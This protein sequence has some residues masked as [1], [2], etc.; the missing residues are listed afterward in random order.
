MRCHCSRSWGTL[1]ETCHV[2]RCV[3]VRLS[4]PHFPD[5][6][7]W[8]YRVSPASYSIERTYNVP[9]CSHIMCLSV[10]H[11]TTSRPLSMNGKHQVVVF[12][13]ES[14]DL[15]RLPIHKLKTSEYEQVKVPRFKKRF[16]VWAPSE[17]DRSS[18]EDKS[19]RHTVVTRSTDNVQG[20]SFVAR[21]YYYHLG[22]APNVQRVYSSKHRTL[23]IGAIPDSKWS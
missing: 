3:Y 22:L 10:L 19:A 2:R 7:R 11:P 23:Y 14:C 9:L 17:F 12:D 18:P 15:R 13:P 8:C 20:R 21:L 4:C 16:S 5:R 1:P 6:Y